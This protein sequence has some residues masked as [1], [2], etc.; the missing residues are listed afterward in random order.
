MI[1][2]GRL[3]GECDWPHPGP[4]STTND[5]SK[6]PRLNSM[7]LTDYTTPLTIETSP[8]PPV[9]PSTDTASETGSTFN[10]PQQQVSGGESSE[11]SPS[12]GGI[13]GAGSGNYQ[14]L[15]VVRLA[16]PTGPITTTAGTQ[17]PTVASSGHSAGVPSTV[18]FPAPTSS[19]VG[20]LQS[21]TISEGSGQID[22]AMDTAST[23]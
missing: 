3:K 19:T 11:S 10:S 16:P 23:G 12:Q 5:S 7:P 18:A 2:L 13:G 14:R 8:V 20:N 9:T 6:D 21:S 17:M 22:E 1:K 4:R 15:V